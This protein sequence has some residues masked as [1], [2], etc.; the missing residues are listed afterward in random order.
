MR[1]D[2]TVGFDEV[3]HASYIA[4]LQYYGVTWPALENMR[5]LDPSSFRFTAEAN[6]LNHPSPFYVLMAH[7]APKLEGHPGAIIVYR[8]LNIM[9]A[10]IGLA[11]LMA[12]GLLARVGRITL[13]AYIIPLICIPILPSLAGSVNNDNAAFAG[14]SIA[15]LALSQV[16]ATGKR[17][18]LFVALGGLIFAS[19]AKFNGL[20][21]TGA[22][23]SVVFVWMF[24]R[25]RLQFNWLVLIV[26]ATLVAAAPY[27]ALIL[28]YG[29]PTPSTPGHIAVIKA[30]A[31]AA[32]WDQAERMALPT[33]ALNFITDFFVNWFP[34]L[35][36]RT[37]LNHLALT[38]PAIVVLCAF[39]G[40]VISG[41]RIAKGK[42]SPIDV[43]LSAGALAFSATFV[44]HVA[45]S[46]QRHLDFGW[47]MDA[48]P[49]YYLPIAALIPLAGFSLLAAI[50]DQRMR[51]LLAG[52]LISSPIL[53]LLL[54]AP[55]QSL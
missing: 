52:V 3:A 28:Q 53:F 26:L 40:L 21:L 4:H 30:G 44:I 19:W 36:P 48:F 14:G 38:M 32:G 50:T 15:A 55:L 43:L 8:L 13:Y 2:V 23:V 20:L 12:I 22:M 17:S 35:T 49:R 46:Y 10:V 47:M 27:L 45:F 1:K 25:G 41:Q 9:L 24:G 5:M 34:V 6:Y 54:G 31:H 33:Y 42:E 11:S 51:T 39:A 16:I 37:T 29:S 7:L 18:W